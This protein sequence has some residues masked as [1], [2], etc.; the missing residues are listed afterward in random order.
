MV[1]QLEQ[2]LGRQWIGKDRN[3]LIASAGAPDQVEDD[4]LGG[5]IFSYVKI[6][7]YTL[8][9]RESMKPIDYT[10]NKGWHYRGVNKSRYYPLHTLMK[11][12]N[13]MFWINPAGQIYR[14]SIAR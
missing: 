7:T 1:A 10:S 12:R 5:Q 3:S 9:L 14:V 11:G 6:T 4:G 8:P 13:T 2:K